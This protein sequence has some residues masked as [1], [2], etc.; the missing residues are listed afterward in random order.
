MSDFPQVAPTW[1]VV[2]AAILD[3]L[4]AFFVGGF[5]IDGATGNLTPD[6]FKLNGA[7]ALLLFVLIAAYFM[8]GKRL[9]GGM[10]WKRI[11]GIAA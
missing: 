9:F 5:A 2:L 6:G 1:K 3:F 8:A 7:L 10:I 4:M 11:F